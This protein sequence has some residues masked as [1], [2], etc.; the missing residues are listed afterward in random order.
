MNNFDSTRPSDDRSQDFQSNPITSG[1]VQQ[2]ATD[3]SFVNTPEFGLD[4]LNRDKSTLETSAHN[5]LPGHDHSKP[6]YNEQDSFVNIPG[7]FPGDRSSNKN[8]GLAGLNSGN[9]THDSQHRANPDVSTTL[10]SAKDTIGADIG[11]N[12]QYARN[13]K[14]TGLYDHTNTPDRVNPDV[15][16]TL[17]GTKNTIGADLGSNNP[18]NNQHD[19]LVDS[20]LYDISS[21]NRGNHDID[22]LTHDINRTSFDDKSAQDMEHLQ[23]RSGLGANDDISTRAMH[24]VPMVSSHP[25]SNPFSPNDSLS[26]RNESTLNEFEHDGNTGLGST[27]DRQINEYKRDISNP[28]EHTSVASELGRSS[29]SGANSGLDSNTYSDTH[30]SSHLEN[31]LGSGA[32]SGMASGAPILPMYQ[33]SST[34]RDS[35]V[36]RNFGSNTN[37]PISSDNHETIKPHYDELTTEDVLIDSYGNPSRRPNPTGKKLAESNDITNITGHI[38]HKN[39]NPISEHSDKNELTTEEVLT[40]SFGNPS[41]KTNPIA[42][43]L[44]ESN[45][46]TD[47]TGH[48]QTEHRNFDSHS[49]YTFNPTNPQSD[50]PHGVS[51]V[52]NVAHSHDDS[53]APSL[54]SSTNPQPDTFPQGGASTTGATDHLYRNLHTITTPTSNIT[55]AN[56]SNLGGDSRTLGDS[57]HVDSN[58]LPSTDRNKARHDNLSKAVTLKDNDS[59]SDELKNTHHHNLATLPSNSTH[60]DNGLSDETNNTAIHHDESTEAT[61]GTASALG[62][63]IMGK[64]KQVAGSILGN[65]DMKAE[66]YTTQIEAKRDLQEARDMHTRD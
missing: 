45:E 29:E 36:D 22:Q 47:I 4:S 13:I 57:S 35:A 14:T 60:N 26:G 28:A 59:K 34:H 32:T 10:H 21:A 24:N 9:L 42:P 38:N 6:L 48:D 41:R 49:D 8:E 37:N 50:Q 51:G 46:I 25:A 31:V 2:R 3:P 55:D 15:S 40:D 62:N 17:Q 52:L 43:K 12:N 58:D 44:V 16:A 56:T 30:H 20:G 61:T 65:E 33:E 7:S 54:Q 18:F 5:I 23:Q 27:V 63:I 64:I 39:Q 19:H 1:S 53:L 11:S 66:G